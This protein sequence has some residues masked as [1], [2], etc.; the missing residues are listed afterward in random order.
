V[1][2]YL[3][4]VLLHRAA[5]GQRVWAEQGTMVFADVSGFTKLSER[6]AR[7]GKAGAEELVGAISS[8]FTHLLTESG[9]YGGDVLKFGGDAL[10]LFFSGEGHL[11]RACR[12]SHGMRR[13]LRQAG[14]ISTSS[15]E[16]I[17]RMS[18][19]VHTGTFH[20]FLVGGRHQ[21]LVVAG[22][23]A[24][25]TVDMESAA[26]A[27]EILLSPAAAA[28]LDPKSVGEEKAGGRL[29]AS[30]PKADIVGE[31]DAMRIAAE[32][33]AA[34]ADLDTFVPLAL[35]GRLG[36]VVEESEH[37]QVAVAF[38]HFGGVDALLTEAGP[39]EVHARLDRLTSAVVTAMD[40][41]G[42]TV[43]CTDIGPDGGKFMLAAGAPEAF[44]DSEERMLR[45]LRQ[46]LDGEYGL[47]IR[48]G[49]N[50]GHVYAGA[51][52]A[53]F[54]FTYSTMGDAV[55]LA[56]RVMGKAGPGQLLATEAVVQRCPGRF[57]T[58]ALAPFMVKGKSLPVRALAVNRPMRAGRR[59]VIGDQ[60]FVGRAAELAVFDAAFAAATATGT[61]TGGAGRGS[62]VELVGDAGMGKSRLVGEA[63]ERAGAQG[64]RRVVV[65]CEQYESNTPYFAARLLLRT[66][67]GISLDDDPAAAG[68]DLVGLV[69]ALAPELLAWT[70]LLAMAADATVPT[71]RE[72]DELAPQFR[73]PR[74]HEAAEHLLGQA[75]PDPTLIVFEDSFWMDEASAE[76]VAHV[77]AT[78]ADHP[79][80]LCVSR[81]GVDTG[82]HAGMGY[83]AVAVDLGPL[84]DDDATALLS[85]AID[86]VTIPPHFFSRLVERS[87]GNPLF[88]LELVAACGAQADLDALP[89]SVEAIVSSRLDR[90]AGPDRKLL[91]YA[92]VL[93]A[94]FTGELMHDA[95]A[96]LVAEAADQ[97]AW[98]RLAE[99]V[100]ADDGVYRFR[101]DLFRRVAYEALPFSRR[102]EV[103]GRVGEVL[104]RSSAVHG[105]EAIGL[106]SLHFHHAGRHPE[107]WHYSVAAGD[108]ARG[109]YA[110]V[111][112]A[113]FYRRGLEAARA[114]PEL[115][116]TA[117]AE[118]A[119]V[120]E[121][122]G[123][124]CEVAALYD[125]ASSAYRSVRKLLAADAKGRARVMVKEA[126]LRERLG[127]YTDALR[128]Y[129][130]GLRVIEGLTT[131][132]RAALRARLAVGYA[133]VRYRQG[134]LRECVRWAEGAVPDAE[135]AGD[136]STLA[137][138]YFI[139]DNA[140]T[141]LGR[142]ELK[143]REM[144]LPIYEEIGD[145][146][147]QAN[148]LNNLGIDAYYEGDWEG[149][150][151]LYERSRVAR[152]RAGDVVGAATAANNIGEILSDQGRLDEAETLFRQAR[153]VFRNANYPVGVALATSNLGRAA[154][155]AG[156]IDEATELLSG[157]L[158]GFRAIRADLFVVETQARMAELLVEAERFEQAT[159]LS[160][161]MKGKV[162]AGGSA[163]VAMALRNQGLAAAGMGDVD[164][165]LSVLEESLRLGRE[166]SVMYEV[167]QT[168]LALAALERQV[169]LDERAAEH[170][171]EADAILGRLGARSTRGSAMAGS[172]QGD[173]VKGDGGEDDAVKGDGGEDDAVKGD[174]GEDDAVKGDGGALAAMASAGDLAGV[175]GAYRDAPAGDVKA[176]AEVLREADAYKTAIELYSWLLASGHG[177]P[178]VEFGIGQC[179]G[180]SYDF[181]TALTHLSRAFEAEPD[182]VHGANYYAY[183]LER[184]G[185]FDEAGRWYDVAVA[186]PVGGPED[187]WTLSH[188]CWF[189]EKA[190]RDDE[191]AAAYEAFLAEHPTY[192]WAVKRY[193]LMLLR[194]GQRDRAEGLVRG[195]A[196][197]MPAS[198]FPKLNLLEFLLLDGRGEDEAYAEALTSLGPVGDLALPAQ[199]TVELF[200]YMRLVL[201]ADRPDP[202][203]L[204]RLEAL[205]A[206]LPE[207][208]HRDF[209]DLTDALSQRGGDVKE[210]Q[211]LLQLL[212]K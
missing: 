174:G 73:R 147:G 200:E 201:L 143:Y 166:S 88:L 188:Q 35:R 47:R 108:H 181:D 167:G 99:F 182:R 51:V 190:G 203:R 173:A 93:G 205:A 92:S 134:R 161:A 144:A 31:A 28:G 157:A 64:L 33:V 183:I 7:K 124:V 85:L 22:P 72:V 153:Q 207:S 111:E 75:W 10:L 117:P 13:V 199:V 193:A 53:P 206:A 155:R 128:W 187:L 145:L 69:G 184:N 210:W 32:A 159:A 44:E 160:A 158:D 211:R 170:G 154:G 89:D 151:D 40:A 15:G 12:A 81:R 137:H 192:T 17:L 39:E 136:K 118:V 67:L 30:A 113:E 21:E 9:L 61:A 48:A 197:R 14:R 139:L 140:L 120:N 115:T 66:A 91:R 172:V 191:A 6:L 5:M 79:W 19:G 168:L 41:F 121:A 189:L 59:R 116:A 119:R 77:A 65:E 194:L 178:D 142:P 26:D 156:R 141:D 1:V 25:E 204:A 71:T 110:N 196:E 135:A 34:G 54:R 163:L 80:V 27:G 175:A 84:P 57:E 162:T 58:E 208:V 83:E 24:T 195:A 129:G 90:L 76:L 43:I 112:A 138:A 86:G 127:R 171:R 3:P 146:L 98:A 74:L 52:G 165:A 4:R 169:G 133:V 36:S 202:G 94:R 100:V 122:L 2:D 68:E 164:Q 97:S 103:H 212:L 185:R 131:E 87:S 56:A 50:R 114:L 82:L 126:V 132:E 18:Q 49:V 179:Y 123:D 105:D 62:V 150:L 106:L 63:V 102:R 101:N 177:D 29:L 148:V 198:P 130:R 38:M 37:R 104:E 20:F 16:V 70:P 149:A 45:A 95:L 96:P 8:V 176:A 209:D 42:A 152:E 107:S 23:A 55:N 78:A 186:H 180:K 125:Q 11:A 109:V 46:V 60:P